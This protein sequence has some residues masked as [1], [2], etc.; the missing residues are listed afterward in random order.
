MDKINNC[1]RVSII[2]PVYNVEK[3]LH[4]CLSSIINQTFRDLEIIIINDGSTDSSLNIINEFS[5]IDPRIIVV[6]KKNEG[7][8]KTVN[9]GILL[10]R[11]EY[12]GIIESDD[13]VDNNMFEKLYSIADQNKCDVVKSCWYIHKNGFDKFFTFIPEDDFNNLLNPRQNSSIFYA[14]NSVW[15]AIYKRSFLLEN[16]ISFLETPGASFQDVSFSYKVWLMAKKV[17]FLREAF[18]HY[19]VGHVQSTLSKGKI[20]CICQEL[21]EINKFSILKN[22]QKETFSLRCHLFLINYLWNLDRLSG[23]NKELFRQKF[24]KD[25]NDQKILRGLKYDCF[26][27]RQKYKILHKIY[28]DNTFYLLMLALINISKVFF[29]VKYKNYQK[30]YYIFSIFRIKVKRI[31]WPGVECDNLD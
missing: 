13:F 20:F 15:S 27:L 17:F 8:G 18:V 12:I 9:T 24:I 2:I 29:K 4:E 7:Y 26:T 30:E 14:Q 19:R 25:L 31:N 5:K 16:N 10:A 28:S 3:Y 21:D 6:D 11:G 1:P 22:L 23:D